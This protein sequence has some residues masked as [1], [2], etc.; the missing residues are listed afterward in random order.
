MNTLDLG[1]D[2]AIAK[3]LVVEGIG[4]ASLMLTGCPLVLIEIW[5]IK[6]I[7]RLMNGHPRRRT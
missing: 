7:W 3:S 1:L 4:L 5:G 6:K 2:L